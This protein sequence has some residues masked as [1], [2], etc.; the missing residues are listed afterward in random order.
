MK[1]F[2]LLLSNQ[3]G[4]WNN[5]EQYG[6]FSLIKMQKRCKNLLL[7]GFLVL[8]RKH[9]YEPKSLTANTKRPKI[10]RDLNCLQ[11]TARKREL[12]LGPYNQQGETKIKGLYPTLLTFFITWR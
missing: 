9:M 1:T 3:Y 7:E 2:F 10:L 6:I 5:M 11:Y 8:G 4:T 12:S